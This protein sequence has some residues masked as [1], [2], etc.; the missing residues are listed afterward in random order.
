MG[1]NQQKQGAE[2]ILRQYWGYDTFRDGQWDIIAALLNNRDAL[3]ILPTGGGK[4]ICYQVPA[5]MLP[6]ITLVISPLIALMQD[7]VQR[8]DKLGVPATFIN[9]SLRPSEIDQRWTDIEHGRYKLVY[10]AP[11]RL[12]NE[13][14]LARIERMKV[15]LIAV[16]E[17]H[18]ISEWGYDFRP[19][20]L[21]IASLRELVPDVPIVA[22]TA[23]AT[24][25]VRDDIL[26]HLQLKNPFVLVSGFNRPNL[27]WSIFQ[28]ENKKRKVADVLRGVQGTGVIYAATR[29]AVEEW[30]QWLLAEGEQA[31]A[32]HGGM[33][34]S[35]REQSASGWLAG[36]TRI[37]V[38]TNAFGMGID[39][40]DVRFVIHVD[41]PGAL[42]SYYQEA[43]RAGRDGEK[44]HAVL[45]YRAGDEE[46]PAGLI[47]DS[48][49][50]LDVIQRIYDAICLHARIALGDVPMEPIVVHVPALARQGQASRSTVRVALDT[51]AR[52]GHWS[53]LRGKQHTTMIRFRQSA[54]SVRHYMT[55]LKNQK[56]TDFV[57]VLLRT[58]HADA[59]SDWWD[60]DL[61]LLERKTGL[62]RARLLDGFAFLESRELL[63]WVMPGDQLKLMFA[64][65]R[66][67]KLRLNVRH[68]DMARKRAVRRL[69]DM[70]RYTRSVTC[71]RH[72]LLKYFGENSPEQ[73]G[74]CDIC[75]G[76]HEAVII[77]PED[78]PILRQLLK[79]IRDDVPRAQWFDT[80]QMPD[81]RTPE[82]IAWL[83][84]EEYILA[85]DPLEDQYRLTEKAGLLLKD[86][87]PGE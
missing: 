66:V 17:A 82:L 65:P 48:H 42:E 8:L 43:G 33:T 14:F 2:A 59:F 32:Y 30:Q 72:F 86:W 29:K 60:M 74:T 5:L 15:Q 47:Q 26:L 27:T 35:D 20:Y 58:V 77:T 34:A 1:K 87:E 83:Y 45:L 22:L 41:L 54:R 70:M 21:Q 67:K 49:P 51:L 63:A 13:M 16:D 12:Q 62:P 6:G 78:E 85:I 25:P 52:E 53:V 46:T 76:R 39:K 18:C 50:A 3:G 80:H 73:C 81:S 37:M 38:A 19:A 4:S 31:A 79:F 57:E 11:E 28:V 61:R 56:L 24:P 69:N 64:L 10:L 71:R 40:P 44:G 84:Q 68:L 75:L 36:D 23:T 7:Q 55:N 9:S